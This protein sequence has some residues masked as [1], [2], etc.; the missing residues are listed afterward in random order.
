MVMVERIASSGHPSGQT[1]IR[2]H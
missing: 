1:F 2:N